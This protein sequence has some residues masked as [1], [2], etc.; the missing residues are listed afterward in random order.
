[1]NAIT[2]Q[3]GIT[4]SAAAHFDAIGASGFNLFDRRTIVAGSYAFVGHY[5][6]RGEAIRA[7]LVFA[8]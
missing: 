3:N 7:A 4:V 5:K 1:M 6:T 8:R 2:L